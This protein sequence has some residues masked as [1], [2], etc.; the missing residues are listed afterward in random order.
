MWKIPEG[1]DK[2]IVF[3]LVLLLCVSVY[4]STPADAWNFDLVKLQKNQLFGWN[5]QGNYKTWL[6]IK[7][8]G[9]GLNWGYAGLVYGKKKNLGTITLPSVFDSVSKDASGTE[10]RTPVT[11]ELGDLY[12]D[13]FMYINFQG[14]TAYG[15]S[16]VGKW[17][18]WEVALWY[19]K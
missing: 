15:L 5:Y 6:G 18:F 17:L 2:L 14:M 10:V 1:Y 12:L 9:F 8:Y 7:G 16:D 3:C 4:A 13:T 11:L 19:G